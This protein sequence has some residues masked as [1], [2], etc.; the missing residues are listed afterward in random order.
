MFSSHLVPIQ[1]DG[2]SCAFQTLLSRF[3]VM[4]TLKELKKTSKNHLEKKLGDADFY[5]RFL[6][7]TASD[8]LYIRS[9]L[10]CVVTSLKMIQEAN[11]QDYA[12]LDLS[13]KFRNVPEEVCALFDEDAYDRKKNRFVRTGSP[14]TT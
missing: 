9:D 11:V 6:S 4:K 14:K 5:Q 7:Y 2:W 13:H 8:A 10:Q 3:H 1:P 12:S